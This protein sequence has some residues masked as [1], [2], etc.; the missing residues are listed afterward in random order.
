MKKHL[1]IATYDGIGTHYSGVGTIAKNI[2]SGL[3][4]LSE[5]KQLKVSI[6]YINVDKNSKV[7]NSKCFEAAENLVNKTGGKMIPLCN[8][9]KGQSEWD[10]WRSFNE[11]NY[12]CISLV[13]A[14]N[15]ILEPNEEN[16]IILNDTP[17]L[18]FAKYK[19]LV[20][21]KNI[22][23]F[24]FPLST[25]KN[26]AF[27]DKDWRNNRI[28]AE[29]KCFDMIKEDPN[30]K[31]IALGK[32]FAERMSED[33]GLSFGE[34]DFL[35]NGLCFDKYTDFL[36]KRFI[37]QDL[38]KFGIEIEENKKIIFA[39]G[40]CSIA[41]GFKELAQAWVKACKQLPNHYLILQIPN[42][43]GEAD[44]F[45]EIQ[46]ILSDTPRSVI[47][48]D[49]NPEIWK[50]ILR[51]ENTD[52]VCIPSIMDPFPHTSIEAKLF[53]KKMNYITIISDID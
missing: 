26:H 33:Y 14:L 53:S 9:T 22:K 42:N 45:K 1:I 37:N 44:Y 13:T 46:S 23:C 11:W 50:T 47:L 36:D 25:G 15:I 41:K 34:D 24:Y 10:M 43:S 2:V 18:F 51:T 8:S 27:G 32:K 4:K 29:Q 31:I 21:D 49:F 40:R 48:D 35:Q 19:E 7:F 6:A 5:S 52:V 39:W 20:N 38:K 17:F 30:S 16:F 28:N 12:A 3:D